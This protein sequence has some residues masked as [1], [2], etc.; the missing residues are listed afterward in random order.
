MAFGIDCSFFQP[1]DQETDSVLTG[2]IDAFNIRTIFCLISLEYCT[3]EV[4]Y[5]QFMFIA[6]SM[7]ESRKF[8][9]YKHKLFHLRR[10]RDELFGWEYFLFETVVCLNI[11][12]IWI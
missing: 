5:F 12:Y 2:P 9:A 11:F 3:A 8:S 6:I 4:D 10:L 1:R 7:K